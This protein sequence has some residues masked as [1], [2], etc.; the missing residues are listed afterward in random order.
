MRTVAVALGAGGAGMGLGDGLWALGIG[1]S[2][3]FV[4]SAFASDALTLLE[5]YAIGLVAF[6]FLGAVGAGLVGWGRR[7]RAGA[8]LMAVAA[9]G[10]AAAQVAYG[11]LLADVLPMLARNPVYYVLVSPAS[12]FLVAAVL[13]FFARRTEG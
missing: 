2:I 11:L 12:L 7:F 4:H 13:A 1:P 5:F 3:R 10:V 6:S 9:V 8:L